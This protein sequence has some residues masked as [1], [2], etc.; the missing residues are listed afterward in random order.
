MRR[1]SLLVLLSLISVG[2]SGGLDAASSVAA[3]C[4]AQAIG[5]PIRIPD[6]MPRDLELWKPSGE[7][8]SIGIKQGLLQ[9]LLSREKQAI[10]TLTIGSNQRVTRVHRPD[11]A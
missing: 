5:S 4:N 8:V 9:S 10:C 1:F 2:C 3:I 6:P 11:G 7:Q